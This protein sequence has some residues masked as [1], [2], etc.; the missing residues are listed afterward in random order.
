MRV[1]LSHQ[2]PAQNPQQ[3]QLGLNQVQ[4]YFHVG[5]SWYQPKTSP[6]YVTRRQNQ[7]SSHGVVLFL[8]TQLKQHLNT[9]VD[10]YTQWVVTK[11]ASFLLKITFVTFTSLNH[12]S[13]K[14]FATNILFS[15]VSPFVTAFPANCNDTSQFWNG[16]SAYKLP[17]S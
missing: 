4:G 9:F 7:A 12:T 13:K 14:T 1:L 6:P 8:L 17:H 2:V 10:N 3:V 5:N 15:L 11:D 16:W